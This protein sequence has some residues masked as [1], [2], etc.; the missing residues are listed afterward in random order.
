M[1]HLGKAAVFWLAALMAPV[2]AQ[3]A[4]VCAGYAQ[5]LAGMRES[6]EALR[7]GVDYLAP[8]EDALAA[9]RIEQLEWVERQN[10]ARLAELLDACGWPGPGVG[11]RAAGL[12][13]A[14][15]QTASTD[16]PFQRRL[17]RHLESAVAHRQAPVLYLAITTDRVALLEERPQLFGTQLRQVDACN[18][19][20]YPLD[21]RKQVELRRKEAGL[22]PLEDYKRGINDM[23]VK[24]NCPVPLPEAS[25]SPQ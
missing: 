21:D 15:A 5:E 14:L 24:E 19:N 17:L 13:W 12:A 7:V 3:A 22:P 18:W 10:A 1:A 11:A 8:P 20:Y 16:L 9:R 23:I 2:A 4:P 25:S 6:A